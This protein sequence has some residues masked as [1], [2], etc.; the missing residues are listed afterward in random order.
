M[1]PATA[2]QFPFRLMAVS[3]MARRRK[4]CD[5]TGCPGHALP[6][7]RKMLWSAWYRTDGRKLVARR[8]GRNVAESTA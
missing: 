8:P 6:Y 1:A 3:V 7:S 2:S 5:L 4:S